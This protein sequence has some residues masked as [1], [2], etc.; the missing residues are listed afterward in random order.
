MLKNA[1][2][3]ILVVDDDA[4]I[5]ST[6]L[7]FLKRYD[8]ACE[9]AADGPQALD[10][11]HKQ[12][13]DLVISDISMPKMNGIEFMQAAKNSFPDL[14]FIIMTG[15][16]SEYT[17]EDIINAGATDYLTKPFP[18][19]EL[20]ARIRRIEREEHI[21]K[22]LQ[23]SNTQL[24][25]AIAQSNLMTFEAETVRLELD[26]IFNTSSNGMCLIDVDFNVMRINKALLNLLGLK[27]SNV[28]NKKC[29]EVLN[30][31]SCHT[32]ACPLNQILKGKKEI[33][34][35]L[36]KELVDGK[37][38]HLNITATPYR[39]LDRDLIGVLYDL[40]DITER[41]RYEEQLLL[42]AG[43]FENTLEG[44]CIT[45]PQGRIEKVNPSFTAITGYRADEAIGQ[46]H[47]LFK[48]NRQGA[49]ACRTFKDS[50]VKNG[51]W[52]G[53]IENYRKDGETYIEGLSITAI[54]NSQGKVT[55]YVSVFRDITAIK[56]SEEQIKHQATHD[57]LTGLPNRQLFND[58]LRKA[59]A[60]ARRYQQKLA[61]MFLDLDNFKNINDSLGHQV[62]DL[63]LQE[64]SKRLKS[65]CRD[66]DTVARQGGDEF[67][68][69]LPDI[70]K[71]EH[72]VV[73]MAQRIIETFAEPIILKGHELFARASIGITLY[74]NDGNDGATLLKNADMAMY[75][76][77]KKGK[78]SYT[79]F[80]KKIN[81]AVVR[82]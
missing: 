63:F 41:K 52:K 56:Q 21:L 28:I 75:K 74:P 1:S 8:Y 7:E 67:T 45:N 80:E 19:G 9:L 44:I 64:V 23:T 31:D 73:K 14:N 3:N 38:I 57:A 69:I 13:F 59:L 49:E 33:E 35:D 27:E 22:N 40:K 10:V 71:G 79:L 16:S 62:G 29:Y 18:M 4:M 12:Y 6:M 15:H 2:T 46:T 11:L 5:L 36:E 76:A 24:E 37:K 34:Y 53:E 66:S 77:K 43:V 47:R 42:F 48:P 65:S 25:T 68:L 58:R 55:H 70:K 30:I 17:Y 20:K 32:P 61:V 50:L 54:K 81:D 72:H 51:L 78:N 26:H 60:H 82:R 39:G